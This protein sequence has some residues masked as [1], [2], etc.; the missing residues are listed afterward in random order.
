MQPALPL[1]RFEAVFVRASA[2]LSEGPLAL[3]EGFLVADR[4][5]VW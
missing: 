4:L 1:H 2:S 5:S 3:P